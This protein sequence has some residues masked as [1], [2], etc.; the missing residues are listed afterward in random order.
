VTSATLS[1]AVLLTPSLPLAIGD[2]SAGNAYGLALTFNASGLTAGTSYLLSV[3]GTYQYSSSNLGF[4]VNRFL[5]TEAIPTTGNPSAASEYRIATLASSTAG[6]T[7][8]DGKGVAADSAGDVYAT[9]T[10]PGS[11]GIGAFPVILRVNSPGIAAIVGANISSAP[12]PGCGDGA[13][14][15]GMTDLGGLG[16]DGS[17]NIYVAQLGGGPILKVS[18]GIANCLADAQNFGAFGVVADSLGNVYFSTSGGSVVYE[19]PASGGLLTVGGNGSIGCTGEEIGKPLGLAVDSGGDLYIADPW[20]NAIWKVTPSGRSVV[21]GIPGNANTGFSGDG[22]P[23]TSATLSAPSGVAVDL[24]GNIYIADTTAARIRKVTG[25]II[26]TI[27]GNG[28]SGYSGDGGPARDAAIDFPYSISAGLGGKLYIGQ[29]GDIGDGGDRIRE[30]T[31]AYVPNDFEGNLRSGALLY[32]PASGQEYSALSNGNG[33]YGY[34]PNLF[35]SGFDTVL[36]GDLSGD[37]KAGVIVYNSKTALAAVGMGRGDGTFPFQPLFWSPGYD[38]VETGDI[39]ADGKTDVVLYNSST[40][41]LYTAI[42]NGDGTFTYQYHLTSAGYTFLRLADFT[43]D[44]KAGLLLYRRSDGLASLGVGDGTGRFTFEPLSFSPGYALADAGD[45]NGDGK[46]DIILYNPANGNAA[47][48][49]SNGAG[50]FNFTPLSLSPGFTSIQ[51]GDSTGDGKA[52]VTVYNG[53]TGV[54]FFGTGKGDGTFKFQALS[55]RP[56]YDNIVSED[57][58]G[59]GKADVILYDSATGVEYTGISNGDGTFSYTY[60]YWGVGKILGRFQ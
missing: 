44:G 27:A 40:G 38:F 57:V 3:K 42:S 43:G 23:A 59:D 60:G 1:P 48:G 45:L 10:I 30:L 50:G 33:T 14:T 29:G 54:A 51:L 7:T 53:N 21:A 32:D 9:G 16:V 26:R 55:W 35:S 2:L 13:T 47:T 24:D 5:N 12:F 49:I 6:G 28:N 19:A 41:T 46:A 39:N 18:G 11:S 25:G 20:C 22:G 36:T 31:P 37:G 17:G 4:S 58:N 15:V 8:F 52:D 56:G 34:V